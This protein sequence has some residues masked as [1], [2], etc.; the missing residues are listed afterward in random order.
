[1]HWE[2]KYCDNV[3]PPLTVDG[4]KQCSS[5][6]AEWEDAKMLVKSEEE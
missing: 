5:C 6:G 1:M 2:C 4:D 3:F